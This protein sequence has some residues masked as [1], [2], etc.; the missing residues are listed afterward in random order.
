MAW[1]I[2]G[3]RAPI[4]NDTAG[5][6]FFYFAAMVVFDW[7][8]PALKQSYKRSADRRADDIGDDRR[9]TTGYADKP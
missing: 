7:A 4:I 3:F 8:L 6:W 1:A 5:N 2:P 9:W